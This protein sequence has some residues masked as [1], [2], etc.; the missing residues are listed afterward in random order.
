MKR[1]YKIFGKVKALRDISLEVKKGEIFC[2]LGPNGSG[3]STL[4]NI[5]CGV[6]QPSSGEILCKNDS[7]K[8][9]YFRQWRKSYKRIA[10]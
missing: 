3:K 7:L 5:I 8:H 1:I 2:I 9:H 4:I 10:A 6:I